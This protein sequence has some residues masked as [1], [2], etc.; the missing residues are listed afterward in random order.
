MHWTIC[1]CWKTKNFI[2]LTESHYILNRKCFNFKLEFVHV[3]KHFNKQVL[4]WQTKNGRN[5][6]NKYIFQW[7]YPMIRDSAK[8]NKQITSE[9]LIFSSLFQP[10]EC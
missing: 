7:M 4:T 6:M 2:H 9:Y 1:S 3:S 10:Y 8:I 5:Q